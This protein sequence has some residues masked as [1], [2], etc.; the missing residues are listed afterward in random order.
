MVTKKEVIWNTLGSFFDAL[1]SALLLMFC[2]RLNGTEIAGMFSISFT[3][4]VLL[5]ALGE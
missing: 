3:T 5:N 2:T 1:V 4:A